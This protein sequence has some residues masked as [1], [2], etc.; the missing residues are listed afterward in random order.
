MAAKSPGKTILIVDDDPSCRK[1]VR[2]ILEGVGYQVLDA[3]SVRDALNQIQT[4][5]PDLVVLDL[6]MPEHDGFTF[7]KFR[8]QN[9]LTASIPV[10]VFSLT[11]DDNTVE[12]ALAMGANQFLG[13]PIVASQLLQKLKFL[14]YSQETSSY[15]FP[16]DQAPVVQAEINALVVACSEG[17][18]KVSGVAKLDP[19]SPLRI[20]S[21]SYLRAGGTLLIGRV[22]NK[23]V[24][25]EQDLYSQVVSIIGLSPEE[26]ERFLDWQ[27][28]LR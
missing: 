17:Q 14:L 21:E 13:K 19:G 16:A 18:L 24:E 27:R 6:G 23:R 3:E 20:Q 25:I 9:T 5:H 4:N 28:S 15:Q 2:K 8:A 10:L 26:K 22:D 12:R 11:K 1:L 7:L